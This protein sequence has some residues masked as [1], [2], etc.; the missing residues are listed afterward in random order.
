[1]QLQNRKVKVTV[2][3]SNI[4][5]K[6]ARN[7]LY[8][9]QKN[10][11]LKENS[12]NLTLNSILTD[13]KNVLDLKILV[14]L[15]VS[16]SISQ[17]VF[18]QFM[19]QLDAIRGLSMVKCI[20]VDTEI[21]AMYDYFLVKNNHIVR[22]SGGGGTEFSKFFKKAKELNPDA[23]LL[24]TDGDITGTDAVP[25]PNIPVGYIITHGG[26]VPRYRFGEVILTLPPRTY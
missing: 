6:D 17:Q 24:F 19:R 11:K 26:Y 15:D 2:K 3:K 13:R 4:N 25:D 23:I 14:G 22:L 12:K 20:E 5:I 10:K 16:G 18:S 8:R 21:V 1:V 7:F 9:I